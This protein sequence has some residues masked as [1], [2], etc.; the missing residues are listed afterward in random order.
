[1]RLVLPLATLVAVALCPVTAPAQIA[2]VDACSLIIASEVNTAIGVPVQQGHHLAEP[3]KDQC[4]WSDDSTAGPDHRRVALGI[5]TL[6]VFANMKSSPRLKT[7]PVSGVGDEAYFIFPTGGD[8]IL[9]V[10]KGGVAFQVKVLNGYKVKPH[11]APDDVKAREL[12]LGG[13]AAGRA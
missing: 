10:R 6:S 12:V 13:A 2:N 7:E 9:A 8:P 11:L 1:M 4:R 3:H 5:E